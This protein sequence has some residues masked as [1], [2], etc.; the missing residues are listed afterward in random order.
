MQLRRALTLAVGL[1]CLALFAACAR[2]AP[3]RRPW[4]AIVCLA[5]VACTRGHGSG[6]SD[7]TDRV[8]GAVAVNLSIDAMPN[9][10]TDARL[11]R[12]API[13]QLENAAADEARAFHIGAPPHPKITACA[14]RAQTKAELDGCLSQ[15]IMSIRLEPPDAGHK[16]GAVRPPPTPDCPALAVP[17]W[18]FAASACSDNNTCTTSGAPC[19]TPQEVESRYACGGTSTLDPDILSFVTWNF[20]GNMATSTA[21]TLRPRI[22]PSGSFTITCSSS[23]IATGLTLGTV[24]P[25]SYPPA[26]GGPGSALFADLGASASSY[27]DNWLT[28]STRSASSFV[29]RISTGT[30][31]LMEQ[32][33]AASGAEVDTYASGDSFSVTLPNNLYI[34]DFS[35]EL[36]ADVHS[37]NANIV[38][39]RLPSGFNTPTLQR[40]QI[41]NSRIDANANFSQIV[42]YNT[43]IVGQPNNWD[44]SQLVGGSGNAVTFTGQAQ[45]YGNYAISDAI[46]NGSCIVNEYSQLSVDQVYLDDVGGQFDVNGGIFPING[47]SVYYGTSGVT[48][49]FNGLFTFNDSAL[50]DIGSGLT[51]QGQWWATDPAHVGAPTFGPRTVTQAALENNDVPNGGFARIATSRD[52][53]S[54][55]VSWEGPTPSTSPY[56]WPVNAAYGAGG[57]GRPSGGGPGQL[58]E[59]ADASAPMNVRQVGTLWGPGEIALPGPALFL[60]ADE[61]YLDGSGNV[62]LWQDMSKNG[63][64]FNQNVYPAQRPGYTSP[65]LTFVASSSDLLV[66][67]VNDTLGNNSTV[68]V[69]LETSTT[70]SMAPVQLR[71]I[72]FYTNV[73]SG[74]WGSYNNGYMDC[75]YNIADGNPHVLAL[76]T[77]TPSSVDCYTD[78]K[79]VTVTAGSSFNARSTQLGGYGGAYFN[80]NMG[81]VVGYNALLT[82]QQVDA[83]NTWLGDRWGVASITT[84]SG[85]VSSVTGSGAGISVS[86]TSGAVV[87]Q[88]TGV[89]SL[90]CNAPLSCG[91]TGAVTASL[92]TPLPLTDVTPPTGTGFPYVNSGSWNSAAVTLGGD[93]SEGARSGSS[94]PVTVTGLQG[95]S[96][97]T[98]SPTAGQVLTYS[99]T[100]PGWTPETLLLPFSSSSSNWAFDNSFVNYST[101]SAIQALASAS[102]TAPAAGHVRAQGNWVFANLTGTGTSCASGSSLVNE[103]TYGFGIDT[104][105][106]FTYG[107]AIVVAPATNTEDLTWGAAMSIWPTITSGAHTVYALVQGNNAYAAGCFQVSYDFTVDWTQ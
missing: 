101:S 56:V 100:P 33:F 106:S 78:G 85:G 67:P 23:T 40:T 45:Q 92:S 18:Y 11:R 93:V 21:F 103:T 87:V 13:L 86:P 104:T 98:T 42:A 95:V 63:F 25:K 16:L 49:N 68:F 52:Q 66:S 62:Q 22:G 1:P 48:V 61:V 51:F 105:S 81:A 70:S 43:D 77:R 14:E 99:A 34:A 8:R 88:N 19:C 96:V 64:D 90:T 20:S 47:V 3:R 41:H 31:A 39:C 53:T 102:I 84:S 54:A 7:A 76:R 71:N 75:G 50:A 30:V 69:A 107:R 38:G 36:T 46:L 10:S 17:A 60:D 79:K 57:T 74:D 9:E 65:W 2:R 29:H 37:S 82:D 91:S 15:A 72:I 27:V 12:L 32:P 35:P 26:G 4:L 24:T 89:T 83:V 59:Y 73:G 58:L 44:N 80:G 28:N 5:L 6:T 94:V 55:I 97:L